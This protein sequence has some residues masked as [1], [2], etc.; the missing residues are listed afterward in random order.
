MSYWS[1]TKFADKLR[2]TKKPNSATSKG[3]NI[4][5]AAAA[6]AHPA[7]YWLAET[8]LDA[9]QNTINWPREQLYSAKYWL[10]NR[11]VV[12]THALTSNL[13]RGVWHE[14]DTRMLHGLFDT[15]VD[16]V[17][18]ECAAH[19][20]CWMKPEERAAY[21]PPFWA[22]GWCKT[23]TWRSASAGLDYL[24]WAASL[25]NLWGDVTDPEYG[26]PS[27]QALA[28]IETIALYTWWTTVY[29]NRPDPYDASGWT[30]ICREADTGLDDL[31]DTDKSPEK[32]KLMQDSLKRQAEI[33]TQYDEEDTSMMIR[34]INVRKSLWT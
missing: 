26:L 13:E 21:S 6:A 8:A 9:I 29:P 12:K 28:A 31:F 23:R 3:W 2:G 27:S 14:F 20:I 24:Q 33:E 16:H 4:W 10:M 22:F 11:F 18:V 5:Y 25:E 30:A 17:E 32:E 15:L 7:R 34:L 19:H 1:C